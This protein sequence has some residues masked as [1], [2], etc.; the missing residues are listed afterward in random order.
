MK[1]VGCFR[2][3]EHCDLPRFPSLTPTRLCPL[4]PPEHTSVHH[5]HSYLSKGFTGDLP[6]HIFL[7]VSHFFF[8]DIFSF[9]LPYPPSTVVTTTLWFPLSLVLLSRWRLPRLLSSPAAQVWGTTFLLSSSLRICASQT[10]NREVQQRCFKEE[11]TSSHMF[12]EVGTLSQGAQKRL[13]HSMLYFV[14]VFMQRSA[15]KPLDPCAEC[16]GAK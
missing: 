1:A 15:L 5:L 11:E 8:Q 9:S 7:P 12:C 16:E 3:S 6:T 10:E 13:R 2:L 4:F 14:G